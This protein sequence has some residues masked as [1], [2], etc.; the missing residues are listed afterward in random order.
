M[1]SSRAP[2]GRKGKLTSIYLVEKDRAFDSS[3]VLPVQYEMRVGIKEGLMRIKNYLSL[4]E[5]NTDISDSLFRAPR[6]EKE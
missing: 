2:Y 5:V 3:I 4:V 1:K 6:I